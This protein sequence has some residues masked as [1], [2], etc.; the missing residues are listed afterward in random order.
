MEDPMKK[1]ILLVAAAMFGA[2]ILCGTAISVIG[3]TAPVTMPT[4]TPQPTNAPKPT[5]IPDPCGDLAFDLWKNDGLALMEDALPYLTDGAGLSNPDT[6]D[7][8]RGFASR[9]RALNGPACTKDAQNQM[10]SAFQDFGR[11]FVYANEGDLENAA[12]YFSQGTDH[13]N[14]ATS[15]IARLNAEN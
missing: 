15:L 11:G 2:L 12:L 4:F 8:M 3:G 5:A 9:A 1:I 13:L 10:A 7:I 6:P 14:E